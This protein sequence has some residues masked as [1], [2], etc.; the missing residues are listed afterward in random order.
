MVFACR[1]R[2]RSPDLDGAAEELGADFATTDE[3][4][5]GLG[6]AIDEDLVGRSEELEVDLDEEHEVDEDGS[7]ACAPYL[8][9][10][11][12]CLGSQIGRAHV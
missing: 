1:R 3:L 8:T 5:V 10:Q 2:A 7:S 12:S 4:D 11:M 6:G 9:R